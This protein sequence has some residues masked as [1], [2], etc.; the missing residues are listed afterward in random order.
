MKVNVTRFV[1]VAVGSMIV[2]AVGGF[3]L[4]IENEYCA[5]CSFYCGRS[6]MTSMDTDIWHVKGYLRKFV[7]GESIQALAIDY[8]KSHDGDF[9]LVQRA[10]ESCAADVG[11]V[12]GK[13]PKVLLEIRS[14]DKT[15]AKSAALFCAQRF[16][17]MLEE[18]HRCVLDQY[19]ARAKVQIEKAKRAGTPVPEETLREI[20]SIKAILEK[21]SYKV[22]GINLV[23][24]ESLGWC[25]RRLD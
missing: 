5:S 16:S 4:L 7:Q 25:C 24:V 20:E 11:D 19:T 21:E 12:G 17:A 14:R 15:L 22:F 18:R 6:T 10:F 3:C 1:L 2:A 23:K 13:M 8:S 9:A